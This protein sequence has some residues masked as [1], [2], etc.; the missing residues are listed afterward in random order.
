[1]L[2]WAALLIGFDQGTKWVIYRWFMEARGD[3]IP[4]LIG[5]RP[6]F[7]NKYSFVNSWMYEHGGVDTGLLLHLALFTV[8]WVFI[9]Q[10]YLFYK[11]FAPDNRLL[12]IAMVFQVAAFASA[13]LSILFWEKGVLDFLYIVPTKFIVCDWKDIYLNCFCVLFILSTLLI[14]PKHKIRS[15]DVTDYFKERACLL[16]ALFRRNKKR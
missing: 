1:M 3:I 13:Y 12:G 14:A 8:I 5:F 11:R 7:N 15:K 2:F 4:G 9:W 16:S 10:L 6:V